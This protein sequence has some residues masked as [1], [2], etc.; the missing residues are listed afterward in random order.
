VLD[1][2]LDAV[3]VGE[4]RAL[5]VRG[6]PGVGKTALLEYVV[7]QASGCRVVRAAGVQSE[8]ELAFAG[9]HQVCAPMLDGLERLPI[10]QRNAVRTALGVSAGPAPD[11]FF[12]ALGVLGLFTDVAEDQPLICLVDDEQWLDRASA[13]VLAFVARRLEADVVGLLFAARKTS[14]E[15]AG[16]PELVVEGLR[17]DDA[18][19]LLDS[20][21]TGPVDVR[22]RDQIVSETRGNPLALSELPRGLTPA[23]LVGGF[24][25][26]PP[27]AVSLSGQIEDSF[28]R[29]LDALPAQTR[30][31]AQLAA[32]DPVGEPLLVWRAAEQL[33]IR[34]Q[35]ATP[36]AEAGLLE[37]GARVRFRHPLVRS[38]AYRSASLQERQDVHR[39]L[40]E[41]TDPERDPDRRAW[42]RAHAAPGPNE[43]VAEE[44]ERSA[45]RAQARVGVAAAA[46]FLEK[47]AMLTRG[48]AR[49]AQR[50]LAAAKA[51]RDAGA[52]DGFVR[53]RHA[54]PVG[55]AR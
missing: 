22:V 32:A 37:F 31:L 41:V 50:L 19:A 42:H 15:L 11:R 7:E 55:P 3:R 40:G 16:L 34:A 9:L 17:E 45:D 27:D 44:L 39:A 4:S 43:D 12:V 46:A 49:R 2:L 47:A 6:E 1:R 18:R 38:A 26:A 29:R 14:D 21:L 35:T 13:Q 8:M 36:A 53:L 25:F 33:G 23:E 5:V 24:R 52:L 20:V 28:R 10:P 54:R 30:R 48:S 51:K